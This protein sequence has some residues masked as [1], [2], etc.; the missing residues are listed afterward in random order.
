VDSVAP[1]LAGE[2]APGEQVLD[3]CCGHGNVVAAL[4]ARGARV[5]ALDFSPDGRRIY[6][7]GIGDVAYSWPVALLD[8]VAPAGTAERSFLR[9]PAEMPNGERQF[10]RK[11][12]ICHALTPPPSR[13]AGPSLHG[14]FGRRAGAVAGYPYSPVLAG[15][16]II[17]SQDTIDRLFELGP[18][19]FIP[20]SKMPMQRIA[21]QDDRRDL[22]E[23]LRAQTAREEE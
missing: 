17:W 19:H 22:I 23:Y 2:A 15:S 8:A 16:D 11:C 21:G 9:D 14:I 6:A 3:M 5:V 20:G 13:K 12:S 1:L 10:M 4:L 18:D 7:G